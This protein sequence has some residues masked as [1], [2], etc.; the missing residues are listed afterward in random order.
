[1]AN[2]LPLNI[3]INGTVTFAP[4]P[5]QGQSTSIALIL[6]PST[7]IDLTTRVR[8]YNTS[9]QVV[10]DFGPN[11]PE[12][13][14]AVAYFSQ[15]PQPSVLLVG[16]WAKTAASGQL[17]GGALTSNQASIAA[18]QA[19]TTGSV[20]F[21]IDGTVRSLSALNFSTAYNLQGVAGV[22]S[23]AL[24]TYGTFVYNSA[25]NRFELTSA[26]TGT[27][28]TVSF[29]T[30]T[31][32]GVDISAMLAMTAASS[33]AYTS[34]GALAETALAALTLIE[35]AMGPQFYGVSVLGLAS[36]TDN[37]GLAQFL[38]STTNKHAYF[39]TSSAG[40]ML[41]PG[42]T[43]SILY[44]LRTAALT[45]SF[46]QYSSSSA[47]AAV[48][49]MAKAINI[50]YAGNS[51][52]SILMYKTEPGVT[53][54]AL[55][56]TQVQALT[57]GYGN[58]FTTYSNGTAILQSGTMVSG[59]FADTVI[60]VDAFY[61]ACQTALF[62]ALYTAPTKIP[63]T[64]IGTGVLVNALAGICRQFVQNGFLAPGTWTNAGFGSLNQG[65]FLQQGFYI[66][67]P[68]VATQS[69]ADRGARKSVT[70]QLAA[71]LAGA[72]QTIQF[73]IT[74]NL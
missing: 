33:G 18:W 32:S 34:Q 60:G 65:D 40:A 52:T 55:N 43:T 53:A 66:Y 59:Q 49:A 42:D 7:V 39:I 38:E 70:L 47:V 20:A 46:V 56:A 3:L 74:V 22:I 6:G 24:T 50:D 69:T 1:M 23:A 8:R 5:A 58:V 13:Q 26:T 21:T 67:A 27:S 45:K 29:A 11:A 12:A 68:P 48:S 10:S 35:N 16:R 62:N 28:S 41:V 54:E 15:T 4:I 14:A 19:I 17:I 61:I 30:P 9:A 64:D 71:K 37:V 31:G 2:S 57:G 72:I 44:L 25:F 63:Q 51:T 73:G 36:E